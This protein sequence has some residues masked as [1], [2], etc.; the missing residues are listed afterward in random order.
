MKKISLLI[1]LVFCIQIAIAQ[2][3]PPGS[4]VTGSSLSST[5][6]LEDV[7][8]LQKEI[9]R[10]HP[11]PFYKNEE[12][13]RK[14]FDQ[15][16]SNLR[17]NI[18]IWNE[19]KI[20]SQMTR[21][22]GLINDGHTAVDPLANMA[23]T[24]QF[25]YFPILLYYFPEGIYVVGTGDTNK[26]IVGKKLVAINNMKIADVIQLMRPLISKDYGN[27]ASLKDGIRFFL[28]IA[29]YLHGLDII[30]NPKE[31]VFT[32]ADEKGN[33]MPVKLEPGSL[34]GL[35]SSLERGNDQ[36]LPLYRQDERKYYWFK[37]LDTVK[38][39]YI[40]YNFELV[41]TTLRPAEF[42]KR[43]QAVIDTAH[44]DKVILDLRQNQGGNIGTLKPFYDFITQP[45]INQPGKLYVLMD[46][47]TQ[48]AATV[49]AI[50]LSMISKAVLIG[51]PAVTAVNFFDNDNK[52]PLPNSKLRVGIST[53]FQT[54]GFS[55]DN[56]KEF[57]ADIPMEITAADYFALRDSMLPY[58]IQHKPTIMSFPQGVIVDEKIAGAYQYSIGQSLQVRKIAEGW[59]MIIE[60]GQNV[61]F[62]STPLY[63][64][65]P[66]SFKTDIKGLTVRSEVNRIVLHT[67]WGSMQ[68]PKFTEGY[69]PPS[70]LIQKGEVEKAITEIKRLYGLATKFNGRE[71]E[72]VINTWGYQLVNSKDLPN[73]LK[74]FKLNTKLFAD[75]GNVWDSLGEANALAGNKEEAIKNYQKA[76]ELTQGLI[77]ATKALEKLQ[78]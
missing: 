70:L 13:D 45:K 16:F 31:A 7:E 1:A 4:P 72:S 35:F 63:P 48:S 44:F 50:R 28:V 24:F 11:D 37:Y 20:V 39:L 41:D 15:L 10:L 53:H 38:T 23:S 55:I 6:W 32:F 33:E 12:M 64:I 14:K 3:T 27:D 30:S 54:A 2:N 26:H 71:F 62:L 43:M 51:E 56:R 46:R 65:T 19:S 47:K 8:F 78:Q 61:N 18:S 17:Q 25:T 76:L 74:L 68:F 49:L 29:Q 59:Q 36:V 40:K 57:D 73:A 58:A 75:S 22:I 60:D 5:Q 42:C 21:I 66:D 52:F 34:Q 69:D 67:I 77:S 9:L